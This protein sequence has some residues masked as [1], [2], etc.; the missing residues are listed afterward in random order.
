M[1]NAVRV[2][3]ATPGDPA[4]LLGRPSSTREEW[5][6]AREADAADL[7]RLLAAG[8]EVGTYVVPLWSN[9]DAERCLRELR[10]FDEARVVVRLAPG[11]GGEAALAALAEAEWAS[12]APPDSL[13]PSGERGEGLASL[14]AFIHACA[15]LEIPMFLPDVENAERAVALAIGED[16]SP[17]EIEAVLHG[18]SAQEP[19]AESLEHARDLLGFAP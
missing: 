4:V 11:E 14:A 12:A 17:R 10:G 13:S 6:G 7:N 16:L 5:E 9:G 3:D 8:G 1:R 18:E 15:G 2:E 19:D